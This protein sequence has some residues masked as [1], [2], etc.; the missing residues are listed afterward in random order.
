MLLFGITLTHLTSTEMANYPVTKLVGITLKLRK[1]NEKFAIM[2]LCSQQN[3]EFGH[4]TLMFCRGWQRNVTKFKTQL[5]NCCFCS[6]NVLFFGVFT[7]VTVLIAQLPNN[8]WLKWYRQK[9]EFN[10]KTRLTLQ[11]ALGLRDNDFLQ[12]CM[13]R[14]Y[15]T[16][17][18]YWAQNTRIKRASVSNTH[19]SASLTR[20]WDTRRKQV[21]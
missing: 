8:S 10:H 21:H 14:I 15:S 9:I 12:Y 2:R 20:A 11:L 6:L 7:A 13:N 5:Q 18:R 1:L 17:R 3:L 4:S 19:A 16:G